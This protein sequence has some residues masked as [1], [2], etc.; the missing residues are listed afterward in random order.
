MMRVI[1]AIRFFFVMVGY[2][3]H[4]LITGRLLEAG[5]RPMHSA[6]R[7][8]A[9]CISL[10]KGLGF[11][12]EVRGSYPKDIPS[13]IVSN[14]IGTL[15]PW[16]LAS[17]FNVAFVA[18][19]EMGTWPVIG[20]VC[21]AVGIIFAHR[22]NVMKTSGTV[23][24]IQ[25][26]MRSGVSVL[27]FPEGTTSNGQQLLPFKTGG[28]QAVAG[29]EDGYIIPMYFHARS[30]GGKE[31][32]TASRETVTWSSPQGMFANIWHVLGL[33]PLHFVIRIGEPIPA[34]GRDRKE[35][36]RSSQEAVQRLMDEE[37]AELTGGYQP[38]PALD[39][40]AVHP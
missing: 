2:S 25:D 34:S 9:G 14:H 39:A 19:A 10:I 38:I 12:A 17:Q 6:L 33:G 28:F 23:N 30:I 7:Q 32:T 3:L 40:Q 21:R 15:D 1:K 24:E 18:K 27:I 37:I 22:K 26:R 8:R 11:T 29:M 16:I 36:A 4:M 31:V 13:L 35:L 5:R 20:M